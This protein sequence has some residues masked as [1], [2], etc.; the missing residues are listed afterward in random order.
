L[1]ALS[2]SADRRVQFHLITRDGKTIPMLARIVGREMVSTPAGT[3]DSYKTELVVTGV[4]GVV[5]QFVLPAM[6]M[7]RRV[8][9]PHAWVRYQGLDGGLGSSEAIMELVRFE[10]ARGSG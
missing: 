10:T 4:R 2:D 3:F 5:A 8:E 1:R 9:P 7:W 6:Y